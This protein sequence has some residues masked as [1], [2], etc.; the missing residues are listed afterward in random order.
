MGRAT[1]S[2][3]AQ[4]VNAATL[5]RLYGREPV[6]AYVDERWRLLPLATGA[7][8]YHRVGRTAIT[9]GAPLGPEDDAAAATS[10]FRQHCRSKGWRPL[11]FQAAAPVDGLRS[12]LIA[13]EAFLD[14]GDFSLGGSAMANARHSVSR[15]RRGG[16]TVS[17]RR[18]SECDAE[19]RAEMALISRSWS[20]AR[21]ELTFTY[22]R[23][24]DIPHE[25]WVGLALAPGGRIEAIS[26]WRPL[27][28]GP[29]LVL[30]LIRRR[31]DSTPGVVELLVVEAVELGRSQGLAWLSLGSTCQSE[32]LPRWLRIALASAKACGGSGLT[33]FK[34]KFRPRWEDRYL[35]LPAGATALAGVTALA[36]AHVRGTPEVR[37]ESTETSR[38]RLPRARWAATAGVTAVMCAFAVGA[39]AHDAGW[40]PVG[41]LQL[42]ASRAGGD[43]VAP[44]RSP[45]PPLAP[46]HPRPAA[47]AQ[48][49]PGNVAAVARPSRVEREGP[50]A[51][52]PAPPIDEPRQPAVSL[53]AS[54]P[55][56]GPTGTAHQ[57]VR[58]SAS[59]GR[60]IRVPLAG[61][62]TGSSTS[63][64][65]QRCGASPE[66]PQPTPRQTPG[67]VPGKQ[68]RPGPPSAPTPPLSPRL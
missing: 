34:E 4:A 13:R 41:P 25:A 60:R 18:W 14:V 50:N 54:G 58:D 9:V 57:A 6:S 43:L 27:P 35:A 52:S 51:G 46:A 61:P 16:M 68:G 53:A 10:A 66:G 20:G 23:L 63:T 45:K 17:W 30:D 62:G 5:S 29:G 3:R 7:V 28:A 33:S 21:P 19:T 2:H 48:R 1:D 42:S 44:I 26:T 47:V 55:C 24:N 56:P 15:A 38:R 65:G 11:I 59:S 8:A 64:P 49:L 39:A 32:D 31:K 40:S 36:I 37:A 67:P 12:H 22:G